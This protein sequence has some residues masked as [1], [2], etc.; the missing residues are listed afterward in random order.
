MIHYQVER[1][2]LELAALQEVISTLEHEIEIELQKIQ[3]KV[4]E[5]HDDT[6]AKD[7]GSLKYF[8]FLFH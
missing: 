1:E 2:K 5:K 7:K 3:E 6:K 4:D 8:I